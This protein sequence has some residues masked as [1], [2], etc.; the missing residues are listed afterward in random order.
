MLSLHGS[1]DMEKYLVSYIPMHKAAS[2][3]HEPSQHSYYKHQAV[4]SSFKFNSA[5]LFHVSLASLTALRSFTSCPW[6]PR[7]SQLHIN[8]EH[9]TNSSS[10]CSLNLPLL[11]DDLSPFNRKLQNHLQAEVLVHTV[12]Y[13]CYH[14]VSSVYTKLTKKTKTNKNKNKTNKRKKYEQ[15]KEKRHNI[16]LIKKPNHKKPKQTSKQKIT[17]NAQSSNWKE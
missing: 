1:F 9:H 5:V 6:N 10:P 8:K 14:V 17:L 11:K 15:K 4:F 7:Q 3:K 16:F 12:N 13:Q 2:N